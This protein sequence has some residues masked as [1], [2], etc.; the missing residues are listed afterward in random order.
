M[1]F[2]IILVALS[3]QYFLK[4]YS[5]S[6]QVNWIGPYFQWITARF[7]ILTKG[8]GLFGVFIF[9]API[10]VAVSLIFTFVYHFL[11]YAGYMVMSLAL[12]W[13]CLDVKFL[14]EKESASISIDKLFLSSY[15][16]CFAILFWYFV[17][18]PIGLVLY[19][20]VAGLYAQL[21]PLSHDHPNLLKYAYLSLAVLDWVPVRL[22]GL[23][24]GLMGHFGAVFQ[25]W[26][27]ALGQGIH[28]DQQYIL[29]WGHAAL[30]F[31]QSSV[32]DQ[33]TTKE[34]ITFLTRVLFVWLVVM[35]LVSL[36]F[37]V[38]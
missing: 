5:A 6:Y 16:T 20:T 10:L 7:E 37:W 24:F 11:G 29:E 9:V 12:V 3:L 17:F 25:T 34:V 26:L 33:P 31:D 14:Q 4:L 2:I 22:L 35:A 8:H 38:G 27:F 23:S 19:V 30:S 32:N 1:S 28:E 15:Q 21:Q 18:G 13:Y 36:G